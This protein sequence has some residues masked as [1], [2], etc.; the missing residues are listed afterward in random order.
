[1]QQGF[2][3]HPTTSEDLT[4]DSFFAPQLLLRFNH[5][6]PAR[7]PDASLKAELHLDAQ[8]R[9]DLA[10]R[11]TDAADAL[12]HLI[13]GQPDETRRELLALRRSILSGKA[14]RALP[15]ESDL[16]APVTAYVTA[17]HEQE[18]LTGALL[19]AL[20][21]QL[22]EEREAL[23]Q[24]CQDE[25]F[26]KAL[27]VSSSSLLGTARQYAETP[28]A[29]QK[30]TLRKS[31]YRLLQYASRAAWKTSPFSHY[32]SV[33]GGRWTPGVPATLLKPEVH[34]SV[35]VNHVLILRLLDQALRTPELRS[36]LPWRLGD[37]LR[38]QGPEVSFEQ[39]LDDPVRQ[40]RARNLASR[41][42][43]LKLNAGLARLIARVNAD[44]GASAVTDLQG[45]LSDLSAD[46]HVQ[47]R[48]LHQ[49]MDSGF[50]RP[51]TGLTE[52]PRDL[53]ADV[54]ALLRR[55]GTAAGLAAADALDTLSG[56][57]LAFPALGSRQ[58]PAALD[59]ARAHL[60]AAYAAYDLAL[61]PGP[62]FYEDT[63]AP[64]AQT[65]DPAPFQTALRQLHQLLSVLRVF[66][67][68]LLF[69]PLI[70][71]RLL[72]TVGAGGRVD[73]IPTFVREHADVFDEWLQA[74]LRGPGEALRA[75]PELQGILTVQREVRATYLNAARAG[76][77]EVNLSDECLQAWRDQLPAH[78]TDRV[79]SY[80]VFAQAGLNAGDATLVVNQ[81]YAGYGQY[82]SRFLPYLPAQVTADVRATL[83]ALTPTGH[84]QLGLRSVH[85]FTANLHPALTP[86]ELEIDAPTDGPALHVN[87]LY[88]QHDPQ[89]DRVVV[90]RQDT[91]EQVQVV[92]AGFLI[93]QL[94][95][96]LKNFLVTLTNNGLIVPHLPDIAESA[97]GPADGRVRRL[98]RLRAGAVILHRARWSVPHA[99]LPAPDQ[100]SDAAYALTLARWA[101]DHGLPEQVFVRR[102]RPART[103]ATLQA[104]QAD[105]AGGTQKPQ[106]LSFSSPLHARLLAKLLRDSPL[107]FVFEECRPLPHEALVHS[108]GQPLT[109]EL[110]FELHHLPRPTGG[111]Q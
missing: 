45:T 57:L 20:D 62:V 100:A 92:Y 90:R 79:W 31:E 110:V 21:G 86:T 2:T 1:M 59:A 73:D 78:L 72:A 85:G 49:L 80:D 39:V 94:L 99:A 6:S 41:R 54:G 108:G 40:P 63:A 52:Q 82:F 46:Q 14:P 96:S 23:R 24:V 88:L 87:Q 10:Q 56:A 38:V 47:Q 61:P 76:Q 53:L 70:R 32:T 66:D 34:S 106:Y 77:A 111:S 68:H 22:A 101:A 74:S 11:R 103:S 36:A 7:L 89:L 29:A 109:T 43:T 64:A 9:A 19:S 12:Y 98:P 65:V 17:W 107:D 105:L 81:V 55:A 69:E 28:L 102:R 37:H 26:L 13:P 60:A 18:R 84:T 35:T 71:A 33:A 5:I 91:G 48:F 95:P 83:R 75:H 104:W 93:A 51:V 67:T 25:Q 4:P 8:R 50:L 16:P 3:L 27:A 15:G 42:V 30:G 44:G 58:R 97:L